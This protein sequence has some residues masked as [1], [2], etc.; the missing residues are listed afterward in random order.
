MNGQS[1]RVQLQYLV[2]TP[3]GVPVGGSMRLSARRTGSGEGRDRGRVAV[4][5]AGD[6]AKRGAGTDAI[7]AR[8]RETNGAANRGTF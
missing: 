1:A 4:R 7:D 3:A 2:E 6:F 8:H 5:P